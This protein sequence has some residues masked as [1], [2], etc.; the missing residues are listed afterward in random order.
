MK[1]GGSRL[2]I[3]SV[4]AVAAGLAMWPASAAEGATVSVGSP[5]SAFNGQHGVSG[6][7][8]TAANVLL[9]EPGAHASSPVNGTITTWH[10]RT[11]TS[12]QIALRVLRPDGG[13][14]Y[15][16]VGRAAQSVA[17][18]G[19]HTFAAN[20]P[21]QSGDLIGIDISDGAAVAA[22]NA[23]GSTYLSWFPALLDGSP[24]A[25]DSSF[26][27]EVLLS[28]DVQYPDPATP[29]TGKKKCKKKKKH[30]AAEAKKKC[31]KKKK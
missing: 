6:A 31:K 13:S 5:L 1:R 26:G 9:A 10:V 30:R 28:A 27:G 20:L 17:S 16:G 22:E 23:N 29:A 2:S 19:P 24:R 25:S 7:N 15:T 14:Q 11:I 21:I 18:P 4:A 3:L 8:G 12:G